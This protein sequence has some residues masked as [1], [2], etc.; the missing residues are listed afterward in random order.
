VETPE[1]A[2]ARVK[3]QGP[4]GKPKG[5][6]L[7]LKPIELGF[8]LEGVNLT[9]IE[10][11]SKPKEQERVLP[12]PQITLR[13]GKKPSESVDIRD[14]QLVLPKFQEPVDLDAAKV[15]QNVLHNDIQ[16]LDVPVYGLTNSSHAKDDILTGPDQQVYE[17]DEVDAAIKQYWDDLVNHDI[18]MTFHHDT[19][20]EWLHL[21]TPIRPGYIWYI[22]Q[23]TYAEVWKELLAVGRDGLYSTFNV[24]MADP[25]G[26]EE[27]SE[28]SAYDIANLSGMIDYVEENKPLV[29]R[30]DWGWAGEA[31]TKPGVKNAVRYNP[32]KWQI[33]NHRE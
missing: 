27:T 9:P 16:R 33:Q 30:M 12:S 13:A 22:D 21:E 29:Y 15:P 25:H 6:E 18:L 19:D 32:G 31:D 11:T 5:K 10:L 1:Q 7:N 14:K 26:A 24:P 8:S 20:D 17:K 23:D 2:W 28:L 4:K 3:A